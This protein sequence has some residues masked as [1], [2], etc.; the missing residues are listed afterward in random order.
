MEKINKKTWFSVSLG[1]LFSLSLV[2][3]AFAGGSASLYLSPPSG[4]YAVDN[5]FSVKIKVNSG[6]EAINAAEGT[7]IFNPDELQVVSLSKSDSIF[8]LWTTEP[9]FSNSTGEIV[10]GGGTAAG[11]TGTSGT[12]ITIT[13][14][15]KSVASSNVNFSSGSVLAA[16]GK[17]T[18]ILG[19][20][21]GGV[22]TL[23]SKITTPPAEEVTPEAECI[24]PTMPS[25]A[26]GAPVISSST[27]PEPNEWYSNNN[28]EFS[29]KVP[30][31][32][33]AVKLLI[34]KIPT[35]LPIVLYTPPISEK[36]LEDLEDGVWYFHIRFENQYG[37]GGITHRKVLIDTEPPETFEL[38]VDNAG[39]PTNPS[40]ILHF[41]T[42]DSLSG[43]EYY[44][45]K[46]GEGDTIP[47]TM[48]ALKTN[49]Y[50]M[51]PQAPGKRSI[52]VKAVDKAGNFTPA[53]TDVVIEPIEPPVITNVP[54][55]VKPGDTLTI[56]GTSLYPDAVVTV[57]VKKEGEEVETRDVGTDEQ[58]NWFFTDDKSLKK[59]TYQVWAEIT[60]NRGAKS[61]STEKITL[62]ATLPIILKFGEITIEYLTLIITLVTLL[63]FLISIIFFA[64]RQLFL[65]R[66]RVKKETKD[67]E[68]SV[69]G[70]FKALREE[71]QKQIEYLDEKAGL[72][73]AEKETHDKLQE[74]LNIF[75]EL[76]KEEI[77]DI[78]KELK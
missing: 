39:D 34:N 68:E 72:T 2:I 47:I 77:E 20:M 28:P 53:T 12:I 9:S 56:K 48:A 21:T 16:D 67:V 42:S 10:F 54:Q 17:G 8:S 66:K 19:N 76:I 41:N 52:I 46:V 31:D 18:N 26:P 57:F 44:E 36:K 32:G 64:L 5:T 63:V 23:K 13:F 55:T 40:P 43:V 37:W 78:E 75:E 7:L 60:D 69:E 29:W 15:A 30:T 24:L 74:A 73:Q 71:V 45:V 3:S 35:S 49:P 33:T 65:W 1:L 50:K 62:A 11:F 14:Q 25:G 58:G 6:G 61:N 4:T 70:A 22:Y 27:H 59:G 51:S 38:E